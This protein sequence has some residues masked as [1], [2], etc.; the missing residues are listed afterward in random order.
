MEP[1]R[2]FLSL[3]FFASL[4]E[5][6]TGLYRIVRENFCDLMPNENFAEKYLQ[7]PMSPA[8]KFVGEKFHL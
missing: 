7:V 5:Y 1:L 4:G 6:K 8:H 3:F 2:D